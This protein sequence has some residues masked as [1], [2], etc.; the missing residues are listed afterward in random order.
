MALRA[1]V[2]IYHLVMTNIA[3][4]KDPPIFKFGNH[5]FLWAMASMAMLNNQSFFSDV[6]VKIYG[7]PER[8]PLKT[9]QRRASFPLDD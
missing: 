1:N 5:L 9:P 4:W 2:C 3:N 6:E 8:L 7:M